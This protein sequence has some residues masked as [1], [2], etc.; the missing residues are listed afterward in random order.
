MD[1]HGESTFLY[2]QKQT[3][4]KTYFRSP[5][6]AL[7]VCFH[8]FHVGENKC[9]YFLHLNFNPNFAWIKISEK[10]CSIRKLPFQTTP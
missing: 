4:E 6:Y 9:E 1:A 3:M 7:E 8:Y 5:L 10:F 2:N